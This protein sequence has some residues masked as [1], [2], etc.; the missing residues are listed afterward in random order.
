METSGE[1]GN[2]TKAPRESHGR[3][4][5]VHVKAP[6]RH[7]GSTCS[8][9]THWNSHG[10]LMEARAPMELA[11]FHKEPPWKSSWKHHGISME[12]PTWSSHGFPMEFPSQ[13]SMGALCFKRSAKKAPIES[14][15]YFPWRRRVIS[16][17]FPVDVLEAQY[18]DGGCR[19]ASVEVPMET[20]PWCVHGAS[21]APAAVFPGRHPW[22]VHGSTPL[23]WVLMNH[24]SFLQGPSRGAYVGL[25]W[26]Y[27]G[28]P[29]VPAV[30][31]HATYMVLPWEKIQY[32]Q[33]HDFP[34]S[35][36][37]DSIV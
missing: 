11:V 9:V 25:P 35:F 21:M 28:A 23:P 7:H 16:K 33:R 13:D 32:E 31:F 26:N 12:V 19:G 27:H 30:C 29:T 18:L 2:L 14:T 22:N 8:H 10:A 37:G 5:E 4:A 3:P 24:S 20:L 1:H 6:Q 17:E 36:H 34:R 15:I